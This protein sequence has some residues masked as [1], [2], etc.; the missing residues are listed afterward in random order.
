MRT[1]KFR[2]WSTSQK[3]MYDRVLAGP[4]DP[5]SIVWDD[6]R[7]D[8]LHFDE[9]CGEIMQYTGLKD[10]NGREIY[11]G[12]ILSG[13]LHRYG[14]EIGDAWNKPYTGVVQ[15]VQRDQ[16]CGYYL[17]DGEGEYMEL[18][19]A[20]DRNVDFN[21]DGLHLEIAGNVHENPGLLNM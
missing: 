5:C 7:K 16:L 11:E 15:W 8:W 10:A 1:L 12:D 13:Q 17:V 2:A 3:K 4:G 18:L 19:Y 20:A 14:Y 6:E 21:G 9:H